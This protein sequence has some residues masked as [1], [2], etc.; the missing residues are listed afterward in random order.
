MPMTAEE[1]N[2]I[3]TAFAE[4]KSRID[5]LEEDQS[6][7]P[8]LT[9]RVQSLE[10]DARTAMGIMDGLTSRAESGLINSAVDDLRQRV[11]TEVGS[12]HSE[13]HSVKNEINKMAN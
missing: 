12:I 10:A 8:S 4:V 2:M 9:I 1:R 11:T 3:D 6:Q 7:V 13:M 5:T